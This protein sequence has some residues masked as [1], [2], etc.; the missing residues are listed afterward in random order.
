M[1]WNTFCSVW[2]DIGW[3]VAW[4][5]AQVVTA[6]Q[7]YRDGREY[8]RTGFRCKYERRTSGAQAAHHRRYRKWANEHPKCRC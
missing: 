5:G 2:G 4:G 3:A 8:K 6:R 1:N 7:K